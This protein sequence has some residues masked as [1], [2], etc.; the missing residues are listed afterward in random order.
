MEI[1]KDIKGFEENY[2]IS[3]FGNVKSK[4]RYVKH[5]YGGLKILRG[6]LRKVTGVGDYLKI[7][8]YPGCKQFTIH[9]LVAEHFIDNP[10][11]YECVLHRDNNP[12][13]NVFSNLYWGTHQMN[14]QQCVNDGRHRGF[15]NG[16][17]I[18]K[19]DKQR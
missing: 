16:V 4:D 12:K 9:R 18:R 17:G 2:Q 1:W 10:N 5:N 13:N 14:N 15:E 19:K 3:N 8:L 11:N 7:D 6:K